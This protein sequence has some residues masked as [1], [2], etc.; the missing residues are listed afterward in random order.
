MKYAIFDS[1]GFPKA[2]YDDEIHDKIPDNAIKITEEEWKEFIEH[3]GKRRYDFTEKRIKKYY[4]RKTKEE[5]KKELK[6]KEISQIQY[7][8]II[9]AIAGD[10]DALTKIKTIAEKIKEIEQQ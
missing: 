4:R 6:G 9:L 7:E 5:K 3:Q 8:D 1:K 10:P 2:F